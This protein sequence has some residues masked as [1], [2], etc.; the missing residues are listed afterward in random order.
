[1]VPTNVLKLTLCHTHLEIGYALIESI[2][3]ISYHS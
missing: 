3:I 1:M 2:Q